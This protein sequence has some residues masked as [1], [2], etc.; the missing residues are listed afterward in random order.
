MKINGLHCIC[1]KYEKKTK[2]KPIYYTPKRKDFIRL[3]IKKQTILLLH[4]ICTIFK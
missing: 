4:Q 2:T 3:K 1:V